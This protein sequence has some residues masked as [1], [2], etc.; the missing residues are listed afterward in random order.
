MSLIEQA[1]DRVRLA[2]AKTKGGLGELAKAAEVDPSAA[3][4]LMRRRPK[5]LE[6]L[7]RLQMAAEKSL[8]QAPA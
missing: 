8:G 4:R 6:H 3:R 1:E 2:A 7:H 5:V